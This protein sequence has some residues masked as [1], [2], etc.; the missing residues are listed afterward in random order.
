[1]PFYCM[2]V[3]F[4]N[5]NYLAFSVQAKL[6]FYIYLVVFIT[7]FLM[8]LIS[9]VFLYFRGEISS[10]KI[11]IKEERT[12]PFFFTGCYYFM[13]YYLMCQL[14]IPM[15]LNATILGAAVSLIIALFINLKWKISIHMIGIGGLIG[16]MFALT[17]LIAA[18]FTLEITLFIF[19]AGLLGTA[20]LKCSDHS[21]GQI[22]AGFAI[23]A[24]IEFITVYLAA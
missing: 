19:L 17:Y 11:P 1:M 9:A 5:P 8:P 15:A 2:A 22:Y 23:G 7:T 24:A 20:R 10:L 3:I 4:L 14:P 16:L 21:S 13:C 6:Q 12:L 18:D